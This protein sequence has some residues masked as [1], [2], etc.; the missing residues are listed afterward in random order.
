[1]GYAQTNPFGFPVTF[2]SYVADAAITST[3]AT[4]TVA[5]RFNL[6]TAFQNH[7]LHCYIDWQYASVDETSGNANNVNN[8]FKL[9]LYQGANA[10]EV[11]RIQDVPT[12]NLLANEK[13]SGGYLHGNR[14]VAAYLNF[15]SDQY[16]NIEFPETD[17][18]NIIFRESQVVLRMYCI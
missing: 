13:R 17:F 14:D 12:F 8:T 2:G 9:Y 10:Y 11:L 1:M 7:V 4:S 15:G 5:G 18:D 3:P 16:V 6:P